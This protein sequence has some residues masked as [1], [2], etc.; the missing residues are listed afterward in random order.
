MHQGALATHDPVARPHLV[1]PNKM[2]PNISQQL[3]G[4][5]DMR[6]SMLFTWPVSGH[7]IIADQCIEVSYSGELRLSP[8]VVRSLPNARWTI[9]GSVS[10]ARM[11][12]SSP[13]IPNW[14]VTIPEGMFVTLPVKEYGNNRDCYAVL[15]MCMLHFIIVKYLL[16][17]QPLNYSW[18][19]TSNQHRD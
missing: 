17:K 15:I 11:K 8:S 10:A 14:S 13:I 12:A 7:N 16:V 3:S 6:R 9:P 19:M 18:A 4:A 2:L 1:C 5:I